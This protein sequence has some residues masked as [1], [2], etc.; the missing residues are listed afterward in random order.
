MK[1]L[2]INLLFAYI[3]FFSEG[4]KKFLEEQPKSIASP[5]T[6]LNSVD[7]FDALLIGAYSNITGWGKVYS[8][9]VLKLNESLVDFQYAPQAPDFSNGNVLSTDYPVNFCWVSNYGIIN[10]A[11]LVLSKIDA[12]AASPQKNR[13]EGEAKFLRAWAY[14]NLVQFF[15]DIP[16]TLEPVI[17]PSAFQP[18]RTAQAEVYNQIVSDLLDAE[19]LM[20]DNAPQ[21]SRVNKWVAKAYLA[22]VYLTMA[23]NPT[24]IAQIDGTNT[25]SLALTKAIEVINSNM[26]KI[27]IPYPDV[28][29]LNGDA[30]TIWEI[31]SPDRSL[32]NHF[33]F[34]SQA[35]FTPVP[36]FINSFDASDVRGPAW[37]IRNSYVSSGTTYNFPLPTYM[38]FVD[39]LQ[40]TKG[41]QFQ[42][43]LSITV[44]R[45]AD[46]YL[47]AAEADNEINGAPSAQAYTWI[48]AIRQRAGI[49]NLVPSLSQLD[50]REAIFIERRKELYGEGFSWFDMRRFN[51]FSL[52]S[53]TGRNFV[54][55][56]DEHLNYYPIYNAEIVN[57]PKVT[58]NPGWPG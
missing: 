13:I 12:I 43:T 14:F 20:N 5:E 19:T 45:L 23:G 51:K 4:C 41:Q 9:D 56:I 58:Q 28:F 22:K 6:V 25:Y 48:N 32:F 57:N 1:K 15:G 11:N 24:K 52:L 10:S 50:F 55:S 54:G 26:Y 34:L 40:Y 47:M 42:S 8:W 17:N 27:N 53:N 2:I 38:K 16:L 30:E 31:R 29:R 7:G 33:T 44:I 39:S 21:P 49:A 46:V 35:I 37:G 3:L 36:E 18:S